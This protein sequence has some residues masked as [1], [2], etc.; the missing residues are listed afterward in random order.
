MARS[1][2]GG[3]GS[4]G[5]GGGRSMGGG[6]RS[7]SRSF[8]GSGRSGIGSSGNH[9]TVGGGSSYRSSSNN[10]Y[11]RSYNRSYGG[12][13]YGGGYGRPYRG[14]GVGCGG[15]FGAI[16]IIVVVFMALGFTALKGGSGKKLNRDK[17]NGAVD[18]S[19]G[20]YM[21]MS[22]GSE[23]FIDIS[24]EAAL[25]SGFKSFYNKTGVFPF[26][27]IVESK[28]SDSQYMDKLYEELFD[29]EGNLLIVYS[30]A[31]DDYYF[32]AGHD[33]GGVIDD[34]SLNLI[35]DK[36]NAEWS[37]GDLAKIFGRGLEKAGKQIMAKSNARVIMITFLVLLAVVLIVFILFKWWKAKVAQKN[38]EQ[39]DLEKILSKPLESFGDSPMSDL[40]KKYENAPGYTPP[41][42]PPA[43]NTPNVPPAN[44]SSNS[45]LWENNAGSQNTYS[46]QDASFWQNAANTNNDQNNN[47]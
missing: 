43:H 27:Y 5:G 41:T 25:N 8:S 39:E 6:S 7:M 23:K 20:Y 28:P 24:N 37:S 10:S 36:V 45:S 15:V 4:R 19:H 33:V 18:S 31:A 14:S 42:T 29:A 47:M 21:D 1:V 2:G 35:C 44:N 9:R 46:G 38:K 11:R 40:E 32:A 3:G 16:I 12:G 34:E 30:A 13:Y 26:L 22:E 17:F